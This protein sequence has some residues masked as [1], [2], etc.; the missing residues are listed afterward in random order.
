MLTSHH[1]F[2]ALVDHFQ[3]L[4]YDSIIRSFVIPLIGNANSSPDGVA[5]DNGSRETQLFISISHCRRIDF[6]RIQAHTHRETRC[7][8]VS[9]DRI[10]T[11]LHLIAPKQFAYEWTAGIP[12]LAG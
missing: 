1:A 4:D 2:V 3:L 7:R 11:H 10:D 8:K 9:H 6:T 5:N 12:V